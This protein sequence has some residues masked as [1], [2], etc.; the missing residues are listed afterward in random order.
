MGISVGKAQVNSACHAAIHGERG[1]VVGAG[2]GASEFVN[3][4]EL[5]D[6]AFKGSMQGGKGQSSVRPNCQV[7]KEE[8]V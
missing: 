8:T 7:A 4:S 5:G 3:R 1:S 2:G 6:G